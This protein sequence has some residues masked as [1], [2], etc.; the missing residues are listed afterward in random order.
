MTKKFKNILTTVLFT[1]LGV[2]LMGWIYRGFD[3]SPLGKVFTVRDNYLWIVLTLVVGVLANIFRSLRWRMLLGGAG[4][5][6]SRGRVIELVFISYLINSVTPR[7]GELTRSLLVRRGDVEVSTKAFGTV[8]VEKLA[9]VMC[10]LLVVISAIIFRWEDTTA[11]VHR[12]LSHVHLT[13]GSYMLYGVLGIGIFALLIF[14]LLRVKR[15]RV[16]FHNLWDGIAAIARLDN[17][18]GFLGLCLSIWACNFLQLYLLVPCFESLSSLTFYDAFYLF[19]A[20]SIGVLLPTPGGAGPWH[21]AIVK[22]LTSVF[23]VDGAVAKLFALVTHGL[24]TAL[25]ILLGLLAY[26]TFYW[27][28]WRKSRKPV[29]RRCPSGSHS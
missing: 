13:T 24:K 2:F 1:L 4:I 25:I 28:V 18:W 16:F 15:F 19:A 23:G 3:F 17:I 12:L 27:E 11:L 9:D 6:I 26:A 29:L 22:T 14:I 7:L 8:V 20:A 21:F 5:P 10:L